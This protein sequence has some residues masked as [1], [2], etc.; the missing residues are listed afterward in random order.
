MGT[1]GGS[2]S[3]RLPSQTRGPC[4]SHC[5]FLAGSRP[6][7]MSAPEPLLGDVPG[8]LAAGPK[9]ADGMELSAQEARMSQVSPVSP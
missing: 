4:T 2:A 5:A 9:A 1:C 3:E 8:Y 7:E 6:S